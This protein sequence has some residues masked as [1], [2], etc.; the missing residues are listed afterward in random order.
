M[1]GINASNDN[2]YY[3]QMRNKDGDGFYKNAASIDNTN[4]GTFTI[5]PEE[6]NQYY[7]R[8][9]LKIESGVTFTNLKMRPMLNIGSTA[10]PYEQYYEGLKDTKPTAIKVHSANLIPFPYD[11]GK[12]VGY[13]VKT[14]GLT[15]TVNADRSI[16]VDGTATVN[17]NVIFGNYYNLPDG[18]YV[19]SA[20]CISGEWVSGAY[21]RNTA[22]DIYNNRLYAKFTSPTRKLTWWGVYVNQGTTVNNLTFKP[23][24][25]RGTTALPYTD[26]IE[27]VTHAIPEALQ[28]TGK[29]VEG[30]SDIID[31]EYK[32]QT[33]K[34]KTIKIGDIGGWSCAGMSGPENTYISTSGWVGPITYNFN[35]FDI[36]LRAKA[37]CDVMPTHTNWQ[38][39]A[40]GILL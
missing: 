25:N 22:S 14:N 26:Y 27:P 11:G 32:K 17:T 24:L 15:Y 31:F 36:P 6:A 39:G 18:D 9:N 30:A 16:T 3:M 7:C 12:D 8:L 38:G 23:I 40:M 29:G 10:L 19:F 4:R 35:D 5:T 33:L 13:S 2:A 34:C 20:N 28:G 37:L 1:S 21:I